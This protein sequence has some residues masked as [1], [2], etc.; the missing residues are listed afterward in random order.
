M[1]PNAPK[2][3]MVHRQAG[4]PVRAPPRWPTRDPT[5]AQAWGLRDGP[6]GWRWLGQAPALGFT[7]AS[8]P[9]SQGASW[10]PAQPGLWGCG[11]AESNPARKCTWEAF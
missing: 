1:A 3:P 4:S 6:Q 11:G 7:P 10:S 2:G 5:R 8:W 9:C